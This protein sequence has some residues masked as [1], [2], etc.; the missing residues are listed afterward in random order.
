M[1]HWDYGFIT[2]SVAIAVI[3]SW[4]SLVVARSQSYCWLAAICLGAGIWSMHFIGML[5]YVMGV[6]VWYDPLMTSVSFLVPIAGTLLGFRMLGRYPPP[7]VGLVIGASIVAMH[8]TG[9]AAME[10][11]AAMV[12]DKVL[13]LLSCAVAWGASTAAVVVAQMRVS[14]PWLRAAAALIL[15][16]A[17]SGMHYTGMAALTMV[18]GTPVDGS[19]DTWRTTMGAVIACVVAVIFTISLAVARQDRR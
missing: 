9:M 5:A 16:I 18:G 7:V 12:W 19:S 1:H 13:V 14:V 4:T 10:T 15:G 11:D 2:V 17:I 3:A 8:Y 6:R